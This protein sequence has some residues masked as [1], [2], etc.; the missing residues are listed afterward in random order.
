MSTGMSS[1]NEVEDALGVLAFAMTGGNNPSRDAFLAAFATDAGKA[2]VRNKVTL[3]H[4]TSEYPA[5]VEDANL[6]AMHTM[7]DAFGIKVGLSDHTEGITVAIA[8][9]ALSAVVIEKHFT[10]DSTLPGPD[11]QASLE[12]EELKAMVLGIRA[13]EHAMGDGIKQPQPSEE[14][15][16]AIV[17][18]SLVALKPI[19]KGEAFTEDNLGV[20]RPGT[21]ASP[22]EYWERLGQTAERGF[23]PDE[24]LDK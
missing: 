22:M 1:L 9:A 19:K 17:R 14:K 4:C 21:G 6:N 3:L 5:P 8:A 16:M 20:K 2:A 23:D 11:H 10:L 18:K 13:V 7:R 15:N 12:P 24:I